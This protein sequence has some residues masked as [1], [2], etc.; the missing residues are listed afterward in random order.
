M[1]YHIDLGGAP[2]NEPCA[3]LGHTPD[4]AAVN[5]FEVNA[6][7][8]AVIALHGLPPKGC[9]LA[10]Y[11]NAHDFGTYRTLVLHIDDEADETVAAYAEAVE[12]GL[13]SWISA[14]FSPPVEYDGCIATIPRREHSEVL[15]GALL[16]SRPRPDGTFAIPDFERVHTNLTAAFPEAAEAARARLAA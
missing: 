13:S 11:A 7:M 12:E 3:Q 8:L 10:P 15:I 9:R 2:A 5:L 4:F 14:C 1:P 16:V 6:Y